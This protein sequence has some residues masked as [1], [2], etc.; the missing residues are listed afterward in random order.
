MYVYCKPIRIVLPVVEW[1]TWL[2]F[3]RPAILLIRELTVQSLL[4]PSLFAC[5]DVSHL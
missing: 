5:L 2:V 1:L 4:H 3:R